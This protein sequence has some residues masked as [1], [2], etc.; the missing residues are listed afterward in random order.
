MQCNTCS[1]IIDRKAERYTVC[2]GKCA[3]RYHA[4]CVGLTDET[5]RALFSKNVL[6]MCDECL[7]DFCNSR[8]ADENNVEADPRADPCCSH[9]SVCETQIEELKLKVTE[10]ME[11]LATMIP[12][13]TQLQPERHSRQHVEQ[14]STPVSP[15]PIH[16][17]HLFHGTKERSVCDTMSDNLSLAQNDHVDTFSLFVTNIDRNTTELDIENLVCEC[18]ETVDRTK[19]RVRRLVSKQREHDCDFV[20]YKID[21]D[22]KWRSLAMKPSTWPSNIKFREFENR[23]TFWKPYRT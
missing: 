20:S 7:L 5:M 12:A 9:Q 17:G 3:K 8:D 13:R 6:W 18:L 21:L 1:H 15:S 14:H 11:T 19:V 2:E 23:C 10:I 4:A 16:N 22:R